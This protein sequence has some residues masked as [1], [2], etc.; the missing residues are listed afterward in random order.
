MELVKICIEIQSWCLYDFEKKISSERNVNDNETP[1]TT[2]LVFC[3]YS[4]F[5]IRIRS[6]DFTLSYAE[7]KWWTCYFDPTL[8]LTI[9]AD[10]HLESQ[11]GIF[12]S[13]ICIKKER[14]E[15]RKKKL[16]IFHRYTLNSKQRK[17]WLNNRSFHCIV[18]FHVQMFWDV[19]D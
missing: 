6:T 4:F 19:F 13:I 17:M 3:F 16:Y 18:L 2:V 12:F 5:Y 1:E 10:M 15:K 14:Q 11:F 8:Y 7:A 9:Y